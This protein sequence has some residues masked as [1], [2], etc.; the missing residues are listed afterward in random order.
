MKK[1]NKKNNIN[2]KEETN[3]N[4]CSINN[5]NSNKCN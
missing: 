3:K 5:S 2:K 4:N 1:Q